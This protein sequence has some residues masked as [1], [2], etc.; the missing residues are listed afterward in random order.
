MMMRDDA[1]D[2]DNADDESRD[3]CASVAFHPSFSQHVPLDTQDHEHIQNTS[4]SL[5]GPNCYHE[6]TAGAQYTMSVWPES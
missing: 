6:F 3:V 2:D 1:D 5:Y 4:L